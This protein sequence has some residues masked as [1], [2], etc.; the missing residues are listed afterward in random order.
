MF[1]MIRC[2]SQDDSFVIEHKTTQLD[3]NRNEATVIL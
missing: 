1:R 3:V 2:H